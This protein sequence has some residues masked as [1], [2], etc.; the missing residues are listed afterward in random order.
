[1]E[2]AIQIFVAVNF[3]VIGL[4]HI[5]QR[6]I[7]IEYFAK[8][9]SLGRLGPT[10]E[11]FLYLNFGALIIAFHNV[12]T[13]P[14]V[15]LTLIGWFQILKAQLR[16]VAPAAVLRI[17]EKMRPERAWQIQMAGGFL[18]AL[19]AFFVFLA[20]KGH[21]KL[22]PFLEQSFS[23]QALSQSIEADSQ[24]GWIDARLIGDF[25]RTVTLQSSFDQIAFVGAQVLA[26]LMNSI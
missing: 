2:S 4:S 16:F 6:S 11:G 5:I 14:E 18:L 15:V 9:H 7:W 3:F 8:L 22:Q 26:D 25:D 10:A 1:M 17:Y 13:I 12:W 24:S 19:S 20:L 21:V 23:S